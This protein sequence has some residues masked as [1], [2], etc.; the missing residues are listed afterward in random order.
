MVTSVSAVRQRSNA[1]TKAD[2]CPMMRST[3]SGQLE[4]PPETIHRL[5]TLDSESIQVFFTS[6]PI[7][8]PFPSIQRKICK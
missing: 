2:F 3:N 6:L 5:H 1:M 8:V 7:A 4:I